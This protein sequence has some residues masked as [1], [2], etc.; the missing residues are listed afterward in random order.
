MAVISTAPLVP[1]NE[2]LRVGSLHSPEVPAVGPRAPGLPQAAVTP[3]VVHIP[4]A[5][6]SP[7]YIVL[8]TV[9]LSL[10]QPF[11]PTLPIHS[12]NYPRLLEAVEWFQ[13]D[14]MARWKFLTC[15]SSTICMKIN[16]ERPSLVSATRE[17]LSYQPCLAHWLSHHCPS[18]HEWLEIA[19]AA[20]S[21]A[22]LE[23]GTAWDAVWEDSGGGEGL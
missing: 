20:F 18:S 9:P 10:F 16:R 23:L 12:F 2:E 4:L 17:R 3:A 5:A 15:Y 14:P 21:A 19:K 6:H 7:R 8:T 11:P 1:V 13:P 22:T